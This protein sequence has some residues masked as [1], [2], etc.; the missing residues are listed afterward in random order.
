M[1]TFNL[2]P[3]KIRYNSTITTLDVSHK[4]K[5][6]FFNKRKKNLNNKKLELKK[7]KKKNRKNR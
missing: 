2:K 1:A 5:V 7:Y 6:C 4:K 3:D